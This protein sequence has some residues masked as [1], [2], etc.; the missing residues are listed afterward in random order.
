[1]LI[2]ITQKLVLQVRL[3]ILLRTSLSYVVFLRAKYREY[4]SN[5]FSHNIVVPHHGKEIKVVKIKFERNKWSFN[6]SP[7]M[8]GSRHCFHDTGYNQS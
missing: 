1:M 5:A 7:M 4:I 8:F 3:E 2:S 6:V